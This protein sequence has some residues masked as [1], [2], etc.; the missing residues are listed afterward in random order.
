MFRSLSSTRIAKDLIRQSRSRSESPGP[1]FL[2]TRE[3]KKP[4]PITQN[5]DIHGHYNFSREEGIVMNSPFENIKVPNVPLDQYVWR[6][7][8]KW[9]NHTAMVSLKRF[10]LHFIYLC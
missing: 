8:S 6:N 1:R 2:S 5:D 9:Q 4:E 10:I 7:I 3:R